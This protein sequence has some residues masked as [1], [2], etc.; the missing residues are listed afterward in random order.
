MNDTKITI[1]RW[2]D[3]PGGKTFAYQAVTEGYRII[4]IEGAVGVKRLGKGLRDL[5]VLDEVM[6]IE[7]LGLIADGFHVTITE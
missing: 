3:K 5:R 4:K 1:R 6:E 2:R 7:I